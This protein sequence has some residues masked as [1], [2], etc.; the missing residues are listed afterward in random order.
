M[1]V[2]SISMYAQREVTKFLGIP[3]D[4]KKSEMIRKLKAKGFEKVPYTDDIL[5]GEFNGREVYI[6]AQTNNNKVW[7]IAILDKGSF[8]ESQ[9]KIHFNNLCEQF[10]SNPKYIVERDSIIQDDERIA[11]NINKKEYDAIYYQ[12]QGPVTL[13]SSERISS[14]CESKYGT[15]ETGDLSEEQRKELFQEYVNDDVFGFTK[16][17]VW[18]KIVE[19]SNKYGK[20]KIVMYYENKYNEANGEDL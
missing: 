13:F 15:K 11:Y 5:T 2:L 14:L 9:I 12:K 19:D 16:N 17:V 7:R 10:R 1:L 3:V 6:S 20:Y 8:N 18:F 4:G